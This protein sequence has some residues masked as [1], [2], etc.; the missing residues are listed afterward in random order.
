MF[1]CIRF[2]PCSFVVF[3]CIEVRVL[4]VRGSKNNKVE[5][6]ENASMHVESGSFF[7]LARVCYSSDA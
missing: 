2:L 5:I 4:Y 7:P 1:D 3:F 6:Y